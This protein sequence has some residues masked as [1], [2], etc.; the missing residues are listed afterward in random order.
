MLLIL[1]VALVAISTVTILTGL[2]AC[3]VVAKE[4]DK[5]IERAQDY[6]RGGD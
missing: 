4:A 5:E 1:G 3:C 6:F 2:W